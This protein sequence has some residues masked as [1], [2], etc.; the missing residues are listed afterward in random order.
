MFRWVW[1]S[2]IP[3]LLA[4][5]TAHGELSFRMSELPTRLGVGYA[6][7]LVDVSGD[8]RLDVVVVDQ[9]RVVSLIAPNWDERALIADQTKPDNVCAA[10]YDIDGDG[11]PEL[12]LGADWRPFDTQS[13]G[14]L[15]WLQ[16][17]K[18]ADEKWSVHPIA[19]YPT[20]H[21]IE[22]AD[23]TGDGRKELLSLPLMGRG[24]SKEKGFSDAPLEFLCYH[25]PAH[26]ARDRWPVET[27][28]GDLHV[29]HNFQVVDLDL[30]GK[31]EILVASAEGV[32][33]LS[34]Q[35]EGKWERRLL[36]SGDQTS[37][38]MPNRGASE[39]KLG[40]L[41]GN[42]PYI[43][44]IEP[45]HG[46]QV[47]VYTP[48]TE[49]NRKGA[50]TRRVIDAELKWGHAV[51][52]A[53]LD[54]DADEELIVGVR[55]DMD[56]QHRCGVRIYDYSAAQGEWKSQRI[57]PGGVAIEDLVAGDLDG[58]G[59]TDIVAVGRK[60]KNIRIYWNTTKSDDPARSP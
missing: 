45:W 24:A 16:R 46:H 10:A 49:E 8:G 18:T 3:F 56:T 50:W 28:C 53:N 20:T 47:V 9:K 21:R 14:T 40:R 58:D 36:G 23:V 52:C 54:A 35:G 30:D 11:A 29:A 25:I 33:L 17:G 6:V 59:R 42:A 12:A 27:L 44:T 41:K 38:P 19:E 51:W 31:Q 39:I 60:T 43:A 32:S 37:L 22:W 4:A 55:D 26:P 13:G 5:T 48:P 57:D 15:Q 1:L 7:K 2:W 34:R